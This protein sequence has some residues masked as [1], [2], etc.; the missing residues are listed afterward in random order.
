MPPLEAGPQSKKRVLVVDDDAE[1]VK[2]VVHYFS[3]DP[4]Y[5]LATA[6]DGFEAGIQTVLAMQKA[7]MEKAAAKRHAAATAATAV[8]EV[9]EP[10][11]LDRPDSI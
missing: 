3:E 8:P 4:D 5:E 6:S 10:A 11:P 1:I 7:V 2:L 9:K